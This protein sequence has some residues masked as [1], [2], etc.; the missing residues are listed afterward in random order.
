[1]SNVN[2]FQ[3]EKDKISLCLGIRAEN[4]TFDKFRYMC[5]TAGCDYHASLPGIGKLS[6]R[7]RPTPEILEKVPGITLISPFELSEKGI[8]RK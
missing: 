5:I 2:F 4:F 7:V 3:I 1:M 6:F 8:A